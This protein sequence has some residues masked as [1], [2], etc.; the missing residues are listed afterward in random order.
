MDL[1]RQMRIEKIDGSCVRLEPITGLT[2]IGGA[3]AG[4]GI[5]AIIVETIEATPDVQFWGALAA[6][7]RFQL[8]ARR[9]G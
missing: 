3:G 5:A 8:I 9:V 7:H 2:S 4:T 6:C 1:W